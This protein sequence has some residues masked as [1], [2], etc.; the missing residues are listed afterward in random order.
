MGLVAPSRL[1]LIKLFELL[2]TICCVALHYHSFFADATHSQM[3]ITGTFCGY[4]VL[5]V[6]VFAGF[7]FAMPISKR[8]DIF[9]SI[10]G[11]ALFIASGALTIQY[12]Q[13]RAKGELRDIG[14]SKGALAI[15]NGVLFVIDAFFSIRTD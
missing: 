13:D 14:L 5:L 6:G 11:A 1:S 3:V 4:L 2:I 8:I 7:I 9:Y 15:I 10:A 12:F